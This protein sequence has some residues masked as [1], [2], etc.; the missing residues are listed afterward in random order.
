[1]EIGVLCALLAGAMWGMVFIA[2]RALPAF[3]P[4][5]LTLGRYL[6]YGVIAGII[7]FVLI[8]GLAWVLRKVSHERLAPPNYDASEPWVIPPGS[9]IPAWMRFIAGRTGLVRDRDEAAAADAV[10]MH[11]SAAPSHDGAS[12]SSYSKHV[13]AAAEPVSPVDMEKEE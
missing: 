1:M 5:E 7:S 11:L 4:W 12:A 8:N 2:P 13:H 3:S 6:A 9:I 10:E